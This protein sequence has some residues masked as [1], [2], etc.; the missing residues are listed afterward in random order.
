MV[1][2]ERG[3]ARI[4]AR[5][6]GPVQCTFLFESSMAQPSKQRGDSRALG[7][8]SGRVRAAEV[9]AEGAGDAVHNVEV[10]TRLTGRPQRGPYPLEAAIKVDESAVF[11]QEGGGRQY[12][13]C[14]LGRLA[15]EDFLHHDQV[16][17]GQ[18][19]PYVC[20][21]RV[22]LRNVLAHHVKR[23]HPAVDRGIEHFG[24]PE[25]RVRRRLDAPHCS[26]PVAHFRVCYPLITRK[27]IGQSSHIRRALD[28]VLAP[29]AEGCRSRGRCPPPP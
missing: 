22:G 26:H 18:R 2:V 23:T 29:A 14:Q 11:F 9:S 16:A 6:T 10:G 27:Q 28:I 25:A 13:I 17:R 19:G 15:Q 3:L 4:A 20:A 1:E 5:A 12:H 8:R 21:V 24:N 7:K